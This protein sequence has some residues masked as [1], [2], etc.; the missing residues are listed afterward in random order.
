MK[1]KSKFEP[2]DEDRAEANKFR[3]LGSPLFET[4]KSKTE[5]EWLRKCPSCGFGITASYTL[6][7]CI[8]CGTALPWASGAESIGE[9]PIKKNLD[10]GEIH[11]V[12][13]PQHGFIADAPLILVIDGIQAYVGSF[14]AGIDARFSRKPGQCRLTVKIA[15]RSRSFDLEIAPGRCCNVVLKHSRSSGN[16]SKEAGVSYTPMSAPSGTSPF[17]NAAKAEVS[18]DHAVVLN[19]EAVHIVKAS[20]KKNK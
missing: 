4:L 20:V 19:D 9:T 3:G 11:V 5:N 15:I 17:E 10:A 18:S 2:S 16:M 8:R 12:F 6:N 13:P 14:L 1:K 7:T